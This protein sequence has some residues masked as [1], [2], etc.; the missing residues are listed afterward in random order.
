MWYPLHHMYQSHLFLLAPD[1]LTLFTDWGHTLMAEHR[2][3]AMET[4]REEHCLFEAM[5]LLATPPTFYILALSSYSDEKIATN[6]KRALN[7]KHKE[8]MDSSFSEV[9]AIP[10][11]DGVSM[12]LL[13]MFQA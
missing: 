7:R 11:L 12:K 8:I 9:D 13:Y 4:L 3:E 10:K 5:Y 6:M 2:D 1:K